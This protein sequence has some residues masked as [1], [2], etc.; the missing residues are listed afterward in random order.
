M[1]LFKIKKRGYGVE[2]KEVKKRRYRGKN[3]EKGRTIYLPFYVDV[4]KVLSFI[5]SE[6]EAYLKARTAEKLKALTD[7]LNNQL[8]K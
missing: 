8:D 4:K 3:G 2:K 1:A 5:E 6:R 7:E